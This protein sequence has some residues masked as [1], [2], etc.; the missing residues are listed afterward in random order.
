MKCFSCG[1][2]GHT[3][4]KCTTNNKVAERNETE[5]ETPTVQLQV[6]PVN[7]NQDG[8]DQTD[9]RAELDSLSKDDEIPKEDAVISHA[10]NEAKCSVN[11]NECA[12]VHS[13]GSGGFETVAAG[14]DDSLPREPGE[15]VGVGV[16][17]DSQAPFDLSQDDVDQLSERGEA[18]SMDK[19]YDSEES[20]IV[21]DFTDVSSQGSAAE[22]KCSLQMKPP[23]Y[24]V[25]AW[26]P[27]RTPPTTFFG[28]EVRSGL[29]PLWSNYARLP[30]GRANQI[31]LVFTNDDCSWR[32][33]M[34]RF[35]YHVCNKRNRQRI[36]FKRR[37]KIVYTHYFPTSS[38]SSVRVCS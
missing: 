5:P 38:S 11:V 2:Y 30:E 12:N 27:A 33:K 17:R 28:R 29:H 13:A 26:V 16:F 8:S 18:Q 36:N 32:S 4:L 31:E 19:S 14:N 7:D 25:L 37:T 22:K 20:D 23:Y 34:F 21:D 9:Q 1:V 10:E 6:A 15:L 3:E 35:R 24:T